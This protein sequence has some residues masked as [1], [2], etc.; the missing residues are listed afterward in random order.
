MANKI[1]S[2]QPTKS[3]IRKFSVYGLD[4]TRHVNALSIYETICKPY[5]TAR[6]T[7]LDNENML[8]GA[9]LVGG[10]MF[11]TAFE[12]E[13][14]NDVYQQNLQLLGVKGVKHNQSTRT[15][16]YT[17][18]LIG[19]TFFK[20]KSTVIQQSLP[21]MTATQAIN[22]IH[23]QN[24]GSTLSIKEGSIGLLSKEAAWNVHSYSP[25]K[26]INDIRREAVYAGVKT[27]STYYY[28]DRH[29]HV[30]TPL[31]TLFKQGIEESFYQKQIY[32]H[33]WPEDLVGPEGV[34]YSI[35]EAAVELDEKRG[36]RTG[37]TDMPSVL[38]QSKTGFDDTSKA[39][40]VEKTTS[41]IEMGS[42][43]GTSLASMLSGILG[44]FS[45]G[46]QGGRNNWPIMSSSRR[47]FSTDPQ[48]KIE[49][50]SLYQAAM[51][52]GPII[53]IRVPIQSG[54][55]VTVGKMIFAKL[56]PPGGDFDTPSQKSYVG[57]KM[58]VTDLMHELKMDDHMMSGTTVM[59]CIKG[60]LE[61]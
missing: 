34:M 13:G 52:N 20:D 25:L 26:A 40:H 28:R 1:Q 10:E 42:A 6:V 51:I 27:G 23:S 55:G 21:M 22:R 11:T 59:T 60:A 37:Q 29:G 58:L 9:D 5:I 38:N 19:D 4:L 14:V 56:L 3:A 43:A 57:G 47:P 49:S 7:V 30:L 36:G 41:A 12:A 8:D 54:I 53:K 24:F 45:Q 61:I 48:S 35:I 39:K 17:M 46:S 33:K 44:S 31:E 18:D 2:L 15:I 16:I 32:G 50:E